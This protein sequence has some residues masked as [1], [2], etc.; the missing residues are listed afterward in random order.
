MRPLIELLFFSDIVFVMANNLD[1]FSASCQTIV[2]PVNT[3]GVMGAGL[4]L[5]FAQRYPKGLAQYKSDCQSGRL[6]PHKVTFYDS[7]DKKFC[8]FPTKEHWKYNSRYDDIKNTLRELYLQYKTAGVTSVAFPRLGCGLGG[9][10]WGI[11][12][13]DIKEFARHVD[14]PVEIYD[15]T[16]NQIL[17]YNGKIDAREHD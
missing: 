14:I 10:D 16:A 12:S 6:K 9:L 7:L 1:I 4:A 2:I 5:N 17:R 11:V 8:F 13:K 15:D 3:V